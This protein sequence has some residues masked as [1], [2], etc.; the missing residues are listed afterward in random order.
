MFSGLL[1]QIKDQKL[2]LAV[3]YVPYSL[4]IG[5]LLLFAARWIEASHIDATDSS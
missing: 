1:P 2:A 5:H 3:L 4:D